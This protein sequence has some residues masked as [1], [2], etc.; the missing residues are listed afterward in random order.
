[1]GGCFRLNLKLSTI[2]ILK[3]FCFR[4]LRSFDIP[5]FLHDRK[6]C[7]YFFRFI[8]LFRL[9]SFRVTFSCSPLLDSDTQPS[10]FPSSAHRSRLTFLMTLEYPPFPPSIT[11]ALTHT[12]RLP[13]PTT[14]QHQILLP[15]LENQSILLKARTG[16][17][18]TVGYAIAA[19]VNAVTKKQNT[20]ILLPTKEL[21][22]QVGHT[23][24]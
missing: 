22:I 5:R 23:I 24:R 1:M 3:E 15:L 16:T 10:S 8:L 11:R 17:G 2:L 7:F 21:G 6:R 20:I 4:H 18:K 19:V 13:H 14:T 12:L 9:F